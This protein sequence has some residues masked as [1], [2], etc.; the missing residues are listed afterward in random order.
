MPPGDALMTS[1]PEAGAKGKMT[2]D[3]GAQN[4]ARGGI[5]QIHQVL[6][7]A[8]F[9][10]TV[11]QACSL[12]LA[13]IYTDGRG[14]YVN[15]GYAPEGGKPGVPGD[16]SQQG[17]DFCRDLEDHLRSRAAQQLV[18]G[19]TFG[20]FAVLA[21]GAGT[22]LTAT[23]PKDPS[24]GRLIVNASLPVLGAALGYLAFGEFT[25]EKNASEI[26]GT[27]ASAINLKDPEA[28]AACNNALAAWDTSRPDSNKI[29]T[30]A[31]KPQ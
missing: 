20:I 28:N 21:V 16:P 15:E 7:P 29:L 12:P 10:S 6:V 23:T 27:A 11:C 4:G 3:G 5:L 13:H 30:D 2:I 31:A 8:L 24:S 22:I 9:L 25:R 26:A 1:F 19:W 18:T 14:G 17:R